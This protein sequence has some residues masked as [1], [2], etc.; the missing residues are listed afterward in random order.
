MRSASDLVEM[1]HK[2]KFYD[3]LPQFS[4]IANIF[5]TI[6]ASS[7]TAERSFS[8]LRRLKTYLRNSMGETRLSNLAL[9]NIE[10]SYVNR[11]IHESMDLIID[12]FG[13]RKLR[14]MYFF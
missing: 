7:C 1:L 2:H 4:H 5:A 10:R 6:P 8:A 13:K 12:T 9:L 11:V 3:L 14:N